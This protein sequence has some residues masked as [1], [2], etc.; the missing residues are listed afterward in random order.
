MKTSEKITNLT[1]AMFEFQT[2]V[3]SVKKS[4]KNP[5]FKS[6]Y[7]DLTSILETINPMTSGVSSKPVSL[8]GLG[9]PALG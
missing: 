7:A 1:K 6:T 5:H 3:A 4:A 9:K 2:K 8:M